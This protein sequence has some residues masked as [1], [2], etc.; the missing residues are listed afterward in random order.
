MRNV[1]PK[2]QRMHEPV[3]LVKNSVIKVIGKRKIIFLGLMNIEKVCDG[4]DR[5]V[6]CMVLGSLN[7]E[8]REWKRVKTSSRT[9]RAA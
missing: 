6:V 9:T 4:E 2:K 1:V 7:Y 5:K 8:D 3:V